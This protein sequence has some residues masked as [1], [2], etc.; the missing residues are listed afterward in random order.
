MKDDL[1]NNIMI[2]SNKEIEDS[3]FAWKI[4][5][6]KFWYINISETGE[7]TLEL[8]KD[9]IW[10]LEG[11]CVWKCRFENYQLKHLE[12]VANCKLLKKT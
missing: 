1:E 8:C 10:A 4:M 5:N 3:G 12:Y 11:A 7:N 9:K 2:E 6:L